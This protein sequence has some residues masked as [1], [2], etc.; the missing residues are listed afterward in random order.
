MRTGAAHAFDADQN[1]LRID[2]FKL[3]P[4]EAPLFQNAQAEVFHEH[5]GL[6]H[7]LTH[8]LAAFRCLHVDGE[9]FLAPLEL[10]EVGFL[11]PE[12]GVFAAMTVTAQACLAAN[13]FR[14]ELAEHARHGRPSGAGGQLDDTY[15][16]K[17]KLTHKVLS[18]W[19][20][21]VLQ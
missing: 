5:V 21:G 13:H 16:F 2:L 19:S 8:K 14:A 17:G 6:F 11:V 20:N 10:H 4:V 1:Y 15:S 9:R 12:L 18:Y 3:G 7:Q